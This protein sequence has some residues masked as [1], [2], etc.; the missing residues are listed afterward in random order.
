MGKAI[1][2][3]AADGARIGAYRADPAG[4]P[5]AGLVVLQE[6]FGVNDHIRSICDRFAAL[7]Y[8]TVAPALFDRVSPGVA[9]GYAGTDFEKG[10]AFR[11]GTNLDTVLADIQAAIDL[12][13]PAGRVGAVG[14]CW[15]GSLAFLS[16][17]RLDRLAAAVGYY[18]AQIAAHAAETPRVP[19]MLHFGERDKSIPLSDVETIRRHHPDTPIFLYAAD[20]GF[21]CDQRASFDKP[22]ADLAL[23]RTLAFFDKH[24]C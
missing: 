19:A 23:E 16:A 10:R 18:G 6:I 13:Q 2:L 21:N 24:L 7:G 5:K 15:G 8:A 20:H 4:Q 3:N 17:T 14:Y 12:L 1:T 9:L 22:S 11:S